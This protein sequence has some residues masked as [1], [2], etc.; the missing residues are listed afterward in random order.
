MSV[1][2]VEGIGCKMA[3]LCPIPAWRSREVNDSGK[4]SLVFSSAMAKDYGAP[5]ELNIPCGQCIGCRVDRATSWAV[6]CMHESQ[7]HDENSFLTL[8]Y[9]NENLPDKG[10]LVKRDVQL[11]IKRLRKFVY[12][13][14][15]R[16]FYC[17]EYG[18]R[19]FRPHYH[20]LLFGLDFHDKTLWKTVKGNSYFI[21]PSLNDI[22]GKGY[23]VIGSLTYDSAQ[24]VSGYIYKK[25]IGKSVNEV[26]PVTGLKPYEVFDSE[27]GEIFGL[28]EKEIEGTYKKIKIWTGRLPEFVC[29][30]RRPGIGDS[31]FEKFGMTDVYPADYV[32]M[33]KSKGGI[34]KCRPPRYYDTKLEENYPFLYEQI[35]RNRVAKAIKH[36]DN[37]TPDRLNVRLK[38][39]K[40]KFIKRNKGEL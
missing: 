2:C 5:S 23:C 25:Q 3:C 35:K 4:R 31:W 21:S 26:D 34:K 38:V 8:T 17:G 24:Y 6:R 13:K 22:W 18:D 20:M 27:T 30:S 1:R 12:P 11:F 40:E 37:N 15:V 29:M 39:M 28:L 14:K 19:T 9:S 36:L 32:V 16:Y 33:L 7:M 10:T